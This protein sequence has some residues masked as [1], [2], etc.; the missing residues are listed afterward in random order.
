MPHGNA[1]NSEGT[2]PQ[3][4]VRLPSH[5]AAI[6]TTTALLGVWLGVV[7][8]AEPLTPWIAGA[9]S[10]GEVRLGFDRSVASGEDDE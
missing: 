8:A 9:V 7:I 1:P 6:V 4:A 10:W 3:P 2:E 5:A